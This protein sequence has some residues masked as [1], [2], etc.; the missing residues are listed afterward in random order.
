MAQRHDVQRARDIL[1]RWCAIAEQRLDHLTEL[2]ETGR[3]RRYHS[4][5]AFME[6]LREAAAAVETWQG[7]ARREA[8]R[9][10]AKVDVSWL[11]RRAGLILSL[12]PEFTTDVPP[13]PSVT[14]EMLAAIPPLIAPARGEPLAV[15]EG[16]TDDAPMVEAP[17]DHPPVEQRYPVLHNAF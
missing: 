11:G 2:Y 16:S 4:E 14:Q 5:T 17:R 13:R 12:R 3:W 6:N 9:D 15:L 1:A 8:T 7:L 10:N